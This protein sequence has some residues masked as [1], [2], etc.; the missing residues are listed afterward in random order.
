MIS[1]RLICLIIA[2]IC[3]LLSAFEW[4]QPP[5]ANFLAGG[6]LFLTIAQLTT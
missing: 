5:R 4:W 3:F 6:L 2:A 1:A